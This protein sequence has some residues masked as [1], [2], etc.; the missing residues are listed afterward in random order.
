MVGRGRGLFGSI[1]YVK[2]HLGDK[3]KGTLTKGPD[4]DKLSAYYN[5]DNGTGKIRG[6]YMQGNAGVRPF[7]QAW[8]APFADLDA[9]TLTISNTG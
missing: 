5:L 7:F 1:N 6:V 9:K 8:L 4:Y 3:V 2:Q